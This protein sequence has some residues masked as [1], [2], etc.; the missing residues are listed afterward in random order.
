[1]A[2][3]D[4]QVQMHCSYPHPQLDVVQINAPEYDSDIDRQTNLLPDIQPSTA[5]HTASTA[6]ESSNAKNIQEDT[7]SVATNS[8][9]HTTSSQDSNRLESQSP[10]VLDNTDHSVYQDTEQPRAEY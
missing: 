6:E 2:Q 7:V 4:R 5:S 1:M 3:L 9:E 10:S 8:E